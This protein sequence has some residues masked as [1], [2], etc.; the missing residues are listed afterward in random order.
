MT[1]ERVSMIAALMKDTRAIGVNG[2]LIVKGLKA[3]MEHFKHLTTGHAVIMGRKT[4]ESLPKFFRPLPNR[5]NIVV[6]SDPNAKFEGAFTAN[7]L[8]AALELAKGAVTGETFIIGGGTLYTEGMQYADRLY[9]T[10]VDPTKPGDVFFPPYEDEFTK[11][12]ER[13]DVP[14][15][16]YHLT[17]LTL[18][19]SS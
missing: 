1:H 14:E 4:W 19:R 8:P 6:T 9:L 7:S 3:D 12:V 10:I 5:I 2:D 16:N 17:F 13:R 11:E 15:V 18:E